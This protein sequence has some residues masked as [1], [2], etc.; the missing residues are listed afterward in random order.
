MKHIRMGH[1]E[2]VSSVRM[3]HK[4]T[5]QGHDD[6]MRH[7]NGNEGRGK[8]MGHLACASCKDGTEKWE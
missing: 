1:Q 3:G 5:K 8:R 2:R 4:N 6:G 7:E